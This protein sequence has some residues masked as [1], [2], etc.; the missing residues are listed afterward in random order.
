MTPTSATAPSIDG[1]Q[2]AGLAAVLGVV[3]LLWDSWAVWPLKVLVVLFHELSHALAALATGG[4]VHGIEVAAGEGGLAITAGGS[5]FVILT[6]GYLGSLL[7]GGVILVLAARF[8]QDRAMASLLGVVLFAAALVWA[9]PL[10]S[11]GFLFAAAAGAAL[12]AAG[13]YLSEGVNDY[14][15]KTIGLTSVLYA[16]LDIRSDILARP[17]LADS[18]AARLAQLTGLPTLFWGLLWMAI[19]L[20]AAY[21]FL[22]LASRGDGRA[23]AAR[24]TEVA[25]RD[26]R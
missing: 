17:D 20:A 25:R 10:A 22:R 9:R 12:V 21:G 23:P 11:F 14:L 24:T 5:R 6:A 13:L 2:L 1:R 3:W 4:S 15:L 16:V 8:R 26:G 18:D 19:A 7:W